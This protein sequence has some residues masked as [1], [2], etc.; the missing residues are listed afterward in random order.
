MSNQRIHVRPDASFPQKIQVVAK[1]IP[2]VAPRRGAEQRPRGVGYWGDPMPT[3]TRHNAGDAL[4]HA[5]MSSAVLEQCVISMGMNIDESRRQDAPAS[6]HN[7]AAPERACSSD[8]CD[9]ISIDGY[10]SREPRLSSPIDH[11]RRRKDKRV[12]NLNRRL[13]HRLCLL[14]T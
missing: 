7:F 12:F 5:A 11:S 8:S 13:R 10:I 6:I 2:F 1:R 9:P 14:P 4:E 3:V